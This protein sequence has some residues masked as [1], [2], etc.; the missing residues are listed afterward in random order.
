MALSDT[1]F[2]AAEEIR[3]YLR[4]GPHMYA[5]VRPQIEVLLADMERIRVM[6][7]TPPP[8]VSN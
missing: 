3:D 4:D 8:G 6:L 7:D 5:E 2:E 1:L